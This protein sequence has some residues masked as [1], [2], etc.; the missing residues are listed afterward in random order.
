[1][2]KLIR[3]V[4]VACFILFIS[5]LPLWAAGKGGGWGAGGNPNKGGG[6]CGVPEIDASL[7]PTAI[8]LLAGGV[9]ILRSKTGR[10]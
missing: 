6:D 1:M 3:V 4:F 10:K 2:G 5:A 8:G 9:L 7:A